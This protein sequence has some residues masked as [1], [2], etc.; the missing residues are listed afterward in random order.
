MNTAVHLSLT[1]LPGSTDTVRFHRTGRI[2][3]VLLSDVERQNV[4]SFDRLYLKGRVLAPIS[5][6]HLSALMGRLRR[7]VTSS[8]AGWQALDVWANEGGHLETEMDEEAMGA[9]PERRSS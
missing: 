1:W 7:H 3:T 9:R 6:R 4:H 5:K 8:A 2:F